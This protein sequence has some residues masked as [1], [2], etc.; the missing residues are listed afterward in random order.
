M[1]STAIEH[2][3]TPVRRNTNQL[4]SGQAQP[5]ARID[6]EA[7]RTGEI[8]GPPH[9]RGTAGSSLSPHAGQGLVTR[10]TQNFSE[11]VTPQRKLAKAPTYTSSF[12]AA[13]LS[14]W[15]N[16]LLIFIPVSWAAHFA[17]LNDTV[18]FIFAF[19]AIIPLASLLSFATEELALRVGQT[20]GGL[21]NAT[22]GNAVEL[23]VT[24]LALIKC[25]LTIVQ[26]SLIGSILSNML[27]VL[28]MCFFVG[29]TKFAEQEVMSTAAQLNSSLLQMSVFAILLPSAFH[30]AIGDS[31][32]VVSEA[33][34]E[35]EILSMSRGTEVI[36]LVI[37]GA[38]LVF[39]LFSHAHLYVDATGPSKSTQFPDS[40][41]VGVRRAARMGFKEREPKVKTQSNE[42][43]DGFTKNLMTRM[44]MGK[45]DEDGSDGVALE[46]ATAEER[47]RAQ[48]EAANGVEGEQT[49][50]ADSRETESEE[51]VEDEEDEEVPLLNL[52]VTI[53]LLILTTIVVGVTAEWLVSAI[54]GLTE[55]HPSLSQEF[56]GLI[57]L[58]IA[59]NAAEHVTAVFA[60]RK[61]KLDLSMSV[62]VGSS[63]Q[64]A[65]FVIPFMVVLAWIMDKPLTM[66]FDAFE[67]IVLFLSVLIVNST[68]SDSR[69]N[70]LEGWILMMCYLL[71][72]VAF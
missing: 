62:A 12:K 56:V 65:L 14:S 15:I 46:G 28:G 55:A 53:G 43:N 31:N 19:L 37:Y 10:L 21:L 7:A 49:L 36:L 33:L 58:P 39:Q 69:S 35:S 66:L 38:Y 63:I 59:G 4:E 30:F 52:P 17:G 25:N 23:I 29:G 3:G 71:L 67:T 72:A 8:G 2:P 18:T 45:K 60:A 32:A 9:R 47:E 42:K 41:K 44:H 50:R 57:L 1:S 64:I 20:L 27:L 40:V 16:V 34:Q 68:L 70:W 61:D 51:S 22:L 24:I 54:D 48:A 26:S 13:F 5:H 6:Q 11:L